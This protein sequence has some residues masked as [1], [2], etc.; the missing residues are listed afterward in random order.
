MFARQNPRTDVSLRMVFSKHVSLAA[1]QELQPTLVDAVR[2]AHE[3]YA[4]LS[5]RHVV[6]GGFAVGVHGRVRATKDVDFLVGGEA[7]L[8]SSSILSF[9]E[10]IPLAA[11]KVPVDSIPIPAGHEATFEQAL[12]DAAAHR[13]DVDGIPIMGVPHLV[14]MKLIAKRRQDLADIVAMLTHASREVVAA[15]RQL[16]GDELPDELALLDELIRESG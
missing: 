2:A 13:L 1:H 14:L 7:F 4:S 9:R 5:V 10:G 15:T 12:D 8:P 6:V 3:R 11:G 16:V